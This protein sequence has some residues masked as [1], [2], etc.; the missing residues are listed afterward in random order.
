MVA[1]SKDNNDFKTSTGRKGGLTTITIE[2][3][4]SGFCVDCTYIGLVEVK[5]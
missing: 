4:E 5:E 1:P 2:S 3:G